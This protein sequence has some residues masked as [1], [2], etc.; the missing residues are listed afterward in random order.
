[1]KKTFIEQRGFLGPIGDDLPSLIPLVFALI[2]FFSVF[3]QTFNTFDRRNAVFNE[4]LN[5][6]KVSDIFVSNSYVTLSGESD[7]TKRCQRAQSIREIKWKAGLLPLDVGQLETKQPNSFF[8]GIDVQKL[9]EQF[10]NMA[11]IEQSINFQFS[12]A[13]T[14]EKP[15]YTSEGT[16]VRSYPVALEVNLLG[17]SIAKK[18][19]YVKPMILVVVTWQ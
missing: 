4:N 17:E 18:R 8:Q 14:E 10:F 5:I 3:T 1:M 6:V 13:N 16:I 11:Q 2:I 7:F 12:C 15:R 9:D 19:F